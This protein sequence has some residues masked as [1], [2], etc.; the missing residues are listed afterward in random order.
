MALRVSAISSSRHEEGIRCV[1]KSLRI[2]VM[3]PSRPYSAPNRSN[4]L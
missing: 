2:N 4:L 1:A 3:E